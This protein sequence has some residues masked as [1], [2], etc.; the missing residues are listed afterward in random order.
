MDKGKIKG[1]VIA[2]IIGCMCISPITTLAAELDSES[3]TQ[4]EDNLLED[5]KSAVKEK[6]KKASEKWNTLTDQQKV[7]I[8]LLLQ[9]QMEVE[10][11]IIDKLAEL[12]ILEKEDAD[13]MKAHLQEGYNKMKENG[14]F[15]FQRGRRGRS[16]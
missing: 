1:L 11:K 4:A 15:P 13:E 3:V 14:E 16:R 8:Y 7:E 10:T 5:R 2:G 6:M 9:Q 12:E